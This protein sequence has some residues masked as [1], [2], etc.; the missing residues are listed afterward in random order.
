MLEKETILELK[1][2]L[3]VDWILFS[4]WGSSRT[5]FEMSDL[6]KMKVCVH[7]DVDIIFTYI[8]L[9]ILVLHTSIN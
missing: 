4:V 5:I 7:S 2:D 8:C 3:L 9:H 6:M 1:D